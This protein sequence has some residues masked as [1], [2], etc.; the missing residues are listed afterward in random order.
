MGVTIRVKQLVTVSWGMVPVIC[1][2][3][4]LK[5]AIEIVDLPQLKNGDAQVAGDF[6]FVKSAAPRR[7]EP[8]GGII[9]SLGGDPHCKH[10]YKLNPELT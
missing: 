9:L 6:V 8:C 1:C 3:L 10:W 4:P 2:S 5:I 7:G